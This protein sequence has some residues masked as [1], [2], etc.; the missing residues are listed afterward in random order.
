MRLRVPAIFLFVAVLAT[1]Q[2][3][4]PV[5]LSQEPHYK[6]LLR[7]DAVR[8][9]LLEVGPR[10]ATEMHRHPLD[11]LLIQLQDTETATTNLTSP[12]SAAIPKQFNDGEMWYA[13]RVT[14]AVKNE[15]PLPLRQLEIE[16]LKRGP[17]ANYSRDLINDAM[18]PKYFPP[19]VDPF[20][21]HFETGTMYNVFLT[22][23]QLLPGVSSQMHEHK[24]PHLVVAMSDLELKDEVEGKPPVTVRLN[25]GEVRWVEG[26]FKHK[27]TNVGN[28]PGQFVTVEYR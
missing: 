19:P 20:G 5:E 4:K 10:E 11:Y 3:S 21:N 15:T 9:W 17:S 12:P 23:S 16:L 14:H 1:G 6:E 2:T 26:G 25:K 28:R 27:L 13:P 22:R 18:Q 7:N 8:V 24:A